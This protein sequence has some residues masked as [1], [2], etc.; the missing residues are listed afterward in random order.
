[1]M[2]IPELVIILGTPASGKTTLARRLGVDLGI[3]CLCKDDV[4]EALF[5]VLGPADRQGSRRFSEA[6]FAALLRLARTQLGAGQ[7]CLV[8]G[9]WRPTHA[10]AVLQVQNQTGA[11]VA[12][13]CCR[14]QPQEI[15]RRFMS[16]T[17]HAGHLDGELSREELHTV[18]KQPP[19]FMALKGPRLLYDSG[20]GASY[21]ALLRGI[22]SWAVASEP[23]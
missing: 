19:A 14:T 3:T 6:S 12:Q 23:L 22:Q 21:A 18:S 10:A 11:R 7:S 2:K 1:M 5:D 4:K 9:N 16:R 20:S 8:E 17:R 13:I 15:A